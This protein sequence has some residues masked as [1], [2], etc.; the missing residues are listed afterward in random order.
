MVAGLVGLV[1]AMVMRESA[2]RPLP[3]AGGSVA[4]LRS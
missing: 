1:V 4:E 2:N 3:G